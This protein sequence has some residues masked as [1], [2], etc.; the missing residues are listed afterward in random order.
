VLPETVKVELDENKVNTAIYL[1]H[2]ET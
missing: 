2:W 1:T